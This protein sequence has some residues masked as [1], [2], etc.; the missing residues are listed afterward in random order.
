MDSISLNQIFQSGEIL[1]PH[2]DN[3]LL[4][5]SSWDEKMEN[6][7]ISKTKGSGATFSIWVTYF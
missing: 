7:C 5:F 4:L 1:I 2:S 3:N 6:L